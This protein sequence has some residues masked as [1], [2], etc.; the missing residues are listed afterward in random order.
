MWQ[1]K[2][3]SHSPF[4]FPSESVCKDEEEEQAP[5]KAPPVF[6]S[7]TSTVS[8]TSSEPTGTDSHCEEDFL[9][10]A[11]S[12][13]VLFYFD[14]F[15]HMPSYLLAVVSVNNSEELSSPMSEEEEEDEE[16]SDQSEEDEEEEDDD[17]EQEDSGSEVEIIEE[18]QGNG[19]LPPLQP[20]SVFVQQG[21]THFLPSVSEQ[22]A[23]EF[24]LI[25]PG[26]E[27]K[28]TNTEPKQL[29]KEILVLSCFKK[30][31]LIH[32]LFIL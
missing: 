2:N 18:V 14:T 15:S 5:V 7:Q 27:M 24:S 32:C 28:V 6:T 22:E 31:I 19:R 20:S 8:V 29:V 9:S 13:T 3:T 26:A 30:K 11:S 10:G 17:E 4:S 21:H 23:A 12:V 16:E 25:A 1:V